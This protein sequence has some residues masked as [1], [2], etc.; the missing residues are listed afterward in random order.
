MYSAVDSLVGTPPMGLL[1]LVADTTPRLQAGNFVTATDP[2]WGTGELIYA[3]ASATIATLGLCTFTPVF[4]STL[5]SWR[6]DAAPVP[7]TANLGKSLAVSLNALASGQYG[8]FVISGIV[9]VSC[10]ASVAADTAWGI[11]AAGQGGALAA[12]KQVL[13]S[14]VLAPATTTV[15]KANCQA[16]SGSTQLLVPSSDGWFIGAYLS[17]TGIAAGTTVAAISPD[18]R[19]VTLSAATTALVSGSVTATYNNATIF[20]NVV[21]LNRSFAQGA[22]T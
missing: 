9:P 5:N 3:R 4:D 12:G 20:Y 10:N 15:V 22:I 8:W 7:N 18:G 1:G 19:T 17:G 21:Q 2:W 16:N 11:V 6:F 13:N 14:R